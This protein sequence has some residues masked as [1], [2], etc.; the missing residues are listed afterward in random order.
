MT[1]NTIGMGDIDELV[2]VFLRLMKLVVKE[3]DQVSR[4]LATMVPNVTLHD[5]VA[6]KDRGPLIGKH[7]RTA[8]ALRT[9]LRVFSVKTSW[10]I[11]MDI[12]DDEDT[13]N[14]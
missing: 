6:P 10:C 2:D 14:R 9:I 11:Q 13:S 4:R 12:S 1:N 5:S 8:K 7:G 3:P